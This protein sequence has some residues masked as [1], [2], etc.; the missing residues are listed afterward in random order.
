MHVRA[1]PG[2]GTEPR[3]LMTRMGHDSPRVAMIYQ[4]ATTVEDR[5]SR[6]DSAV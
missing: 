2:Q 5:R 6:T 1:R 3:R 4:H